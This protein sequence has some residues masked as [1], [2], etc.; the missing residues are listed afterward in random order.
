MGG[1]SHDKN[2]K[3]P[4]TAVAHTADAMEPNVGVS[5]HVCSRQGESIALS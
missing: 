1:I 5:R 3:F 2:N 4:H